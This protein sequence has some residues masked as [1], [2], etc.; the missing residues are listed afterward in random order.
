MQIEKILNN[1]VVQAIDNDVEY[2]VMGKGLGFQKKVGETVDKE[3]IEKTFVLENP[4]TEAEWTR[5][6]VDLSDDEMQVFLNIITFAEAVLQTKFEPSFFIAL[7]DHLH[8]AIERSREGISLQ[9]P[10]AWEIRKFYPREYEIGK[11]A[12]R[13]IAND[14]EVELADDE[15]ASVALHFVNAQKDTGLHEKDRQL[16]QIVVGISEIVRLHF[17]CD[18]E[19]E[20]FSYNRFITHLQYLAQRIVSGVSGGKND[21]FLYEQVKVNY[22]ESFICTQ[23]IVT[24]IK[25]SYAFELSLD[26]QVYL[27][28]HIQRLRDNID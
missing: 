1:N 11:Q 16:T 17:G 20:S 15:S 13:L 19:E 14:L 9:N 21:A 22:P 28:I 7:A 2:I 25:S 4:E 24:Y 18:L 27:T 10:L 12:L 5:V 26:E 3:K 6:Y 23:K 8:Y